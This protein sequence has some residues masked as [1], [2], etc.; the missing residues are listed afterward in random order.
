MRSRVGDE[1]ARAELQVVELAA[2][3]RAARV[4]AD[5]GDEPA[6]GAQRRDVRGDVGGAAETM[7]ARVHRDDGHRRLGRNPLDFAHQVDVE[8]RVADH[9]DL[10][11]GHLAEKGF[12]AVARESGV[13]HGMRPSFF[14]CQVSCTVPTQ[15][16][17]SGPFAIRCTPPSPDNTQ[18]P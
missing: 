5:N 18:R 7:A 15:R 13:G 11:R 9:D 12:D 4:L 16:V 14:V 1:I 17:F 10:G 6:F 3:G 8:H 2:H